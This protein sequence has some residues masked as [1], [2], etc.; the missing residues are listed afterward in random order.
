MKSLKMLV[1]ICVLLQVP[2]FQ[3]KVN[4]QQVPTDSTNVISYVDFVPYMQHCVKASVNG[5]NVLGTFL[6]DSGTSDE[7]GITIDSTFFF[8]HVDTTGLKRVKPAY[9][10]YYWRMHYEGDIQLT[11]G[12]YSFRVK[13][14]TVNNQRRLRLGNEDGIFTGVIDVTPFLNK[15]TIIDSEN[16]RMAFVDTVVIDSTYSVVPLYRSRVSKPVS[17]SQRFI[18]VDGL[19]NKSKKKISGFFLL[20]TGCFGKGLM[21]KTDFANRLKIPLDTKEHDDCIRWYVDSLQVGDIVINNVPLD[22]VKKG[23]FDRYVMLEGGDGLFGINL[24]RRFQLI[25]DYKHD[26]LYLKPNKKY[27]ERNNERNL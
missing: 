4:M 8:N 2:S 25:I 16:H 11:M 1:F 24:L 13:R 26:K 3:A 23:E 19:E 5:S 20:D 18:K 21:L 10:M 12:D 6:V 9:R 27:Y 15:Y 7:V 17:D 14:L 22:R